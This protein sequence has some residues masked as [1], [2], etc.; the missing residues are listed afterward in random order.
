MAD[1][2]LIMAVRVKDRSATDL[3]NKITQGTITTQGN[4]LTRRF[5]NFVEDTLN[6]FLGSVKR[7]NIVATI[8]DTSFT[9]STGNIACVQANASGDTITFT[10]G[11][12]TVVLTEGASGEN[13]FA[14]GASN[15]TCAT[16]L[17]ACINAHSILGPLITA[18]GSVGNCGLTAKVPTCLLQDIAMTT[19]DGTAFSFTQL[20]GGN[21]GAAQF[22]PVHFSTGQTL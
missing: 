10:Y 22:F 1:S 6:S 11:A 4:T 9:A 13:G 7:G 16:N 12:K 5:V 2:W 14:R 18:L 20:T 15:T 21:E 19:S 3:K 8:L 17:A